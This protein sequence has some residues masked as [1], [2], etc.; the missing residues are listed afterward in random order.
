M[1]EHVPG[2][3]GGRACIAGTRIPVWVVEALARDGTHDAQILAAFPSIT[4]EQLHA[5]LRYASEHEAEVNHDIYEQDA[6]V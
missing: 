4:L 2:V 5:A 6:C 3:C 1:I